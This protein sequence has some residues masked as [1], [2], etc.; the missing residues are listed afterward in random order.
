M[1]TQWNA[2]VKSTAA[3]FALCLACP[4]CNSSLR[5]KRNILRKL[6]REYRRLHYRVQMRRQINQNMARNLL[7]KLCPISSSFICFTLKP[8]HI[9]SLTS[10]LEAI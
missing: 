6:F 5:E 2:R 8:Q 1:L 7:P 4:S 10:L 9:V 3:E